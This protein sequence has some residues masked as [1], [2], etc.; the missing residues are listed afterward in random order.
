MSTRTTGH[1][2]L[3]ARVSIWLERD[4]PITHELSDEGHE[5]TVLPETVA[6]LHEMADALKQVGLMPPDADGLARDNVLVQLLLDI[7]GAT[8]P[9]R[10][11]LRWRRIRAGRGA[12]A[13]FR[14]RIQTEI[15]LADHP[16]V[17]EDDALR[18][19]LRSV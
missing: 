11:L 19:L 6:L 10:R 2:P 13:P 15:P 5:L 8:P 17:D 4:P 14:D 7:A 1:L 18:L 16:W 3:T 12:L 9:W